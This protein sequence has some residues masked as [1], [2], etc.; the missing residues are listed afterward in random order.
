MPRYKLLGGRHYEF[1]EGSTQDRVVFQSGEI[2]TSDRDLITLYPNKFEKINE[3]DPIVVTDE[4]RQMVQDLIDDGA[5]QD[6]DRTFLEELSV[7]HF[8]RILRQTPLPVKAKSKAKKSILGDDVTDQFERAAEN[9]MK[10]FVNSAG[11]FQVTTATHTKK[12][13]NKEPF[14]NHDQV[15]AFIEEMAGEQE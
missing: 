13:L 7:E 15:N 8:N 6:D 1:A 4:R 10:V 14:D 12:P 11:K 5:W 3:P 9:D 2:V